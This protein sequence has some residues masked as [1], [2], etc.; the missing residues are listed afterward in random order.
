MI[1]NNLKIIIIVILL[2]A[3]VGWS[4]YLQDIVIAGTAPRARPYTKVSSFLTQKIRAV[5]VH[6][7]VFTDS[8]FSTY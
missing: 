6:A 4:I 5:C 8:N 2:V 7:H 1:S 3:I